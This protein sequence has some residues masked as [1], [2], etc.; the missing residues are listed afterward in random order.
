[1]KIKTI[2]ISVMIIPL[3]SWTTALIAGKLPPAEHL[4]SKIYDYKLKLGENKKVSD[5]I[6]TIVVDDQ[7]VQLGNKWPWPWIN[8]ASVASFLSRT[9]VRVLGIDIR[10]ENYEDNMQGL[11]ALR[12]YYS[13]LGNVVLPYYFKT[14]DNGVS[15]SAQKKDSIDEALNKFAIYVDKDFFRSVPD[16]KNYVLPVNELRNA[17]FMGFTNMDE[18][19]D[20]VVRKAPLIYRQG[21]NY[22]P[23][24]ILMMLCRYYGK[25]ASDIAAENGFVRIK[26]TDISIPVNQRGEMMINFR[27][28]RFKGDPALQILK[29]DRDISQGM[30]PVVPL[31]DYEEKIV[32]YGVGMTGGYDIG[33]IPLSSNKSP[34]L[35]AHANALNTILQKDYVHEV[36]HQALLALIFTALIGAVSLFQRQWLIWTASVFFILG[37]QAMS[38][39]LFSSDNYYINSTLP[40][41]SMTLCLFSST[42]YKLALEIKA[43]QQIKSI[44][45]KYIS[46]SVMDMLLKDPSMLK[47]SGEKKTM[48]VLFSDI[49]GFTSYSENKT[50]DEV[51]AA[52]NAYLDRMTRIILSLNGTVDKYIGDAIMAFWNAPIEQPQHA[53]LAVSAALKMVEELEA[54]KISN[55]GCTFDMGVGIN[56]GEMMVG[57]MG[58]QF[59][60]DYTVIG[61]NVNLASRVEGLTRKYPHRVIVTES[62]YN[63][64]EDFFVMEYL[65][66]VSVKGKDKRIKIYGVKESK[67]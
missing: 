13:M 23:S 36:P 64:I 26:G 22:Y 50:P 21:E 5:I 29:A 56:T 52:L 2:L 33:L 46:K 37:L 9:N 42:G 10:F 14:G 16:A 45:G 53:R 24:Y 12:Y 1:M 8:H 55:E 34:L 17:A 35:L 15:Y 11:E 43:K 61:D 58:S 27:S 18:D 6:R 62:T 57:N 28:L 40:L 4:E 39:V 38:V 30:E 20:G 41:L 25:T 59:I 44:L 54:M 32:I 19:S 65:D 60:Y 7:S 47:L 49:K 51:V 63:K 3:I 67:S 31:S 48:T 66:E